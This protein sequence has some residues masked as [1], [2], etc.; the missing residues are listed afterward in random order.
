MTADSTIARVRA[1]RHAT[2]AEHDD[3]VHKLMAHLIELQKQ[4]KRRLLGR[5]ARKTAKT[6]K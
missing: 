5:R 6:T 1:A 4:N 2:S 3:D